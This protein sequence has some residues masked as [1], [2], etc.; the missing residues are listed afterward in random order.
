MMCFR[1]IY[2]ILLLVNGLPRRYFIF[3]LFSAK[4]THV[5]IENTATLLGKRTMRLAYVNMDTMEPLA[6][7]RHTSWVVKYEILL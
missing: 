3:S 1:I 5:S 2:R 4:K 7:V 6:K